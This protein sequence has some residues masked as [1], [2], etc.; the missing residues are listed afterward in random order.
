MPRAF[1][2]KKQQNKSVEKTN[3]VV[4]AA[5]NDEDED[6]NVEDDEEVATMPAHEAEPRRDVN[7]STGEM[8]Y[9]MHLVQLLR[10]IYDQPA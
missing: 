3:V 7:E 6:V 9:D 4:Y 8:I 10:I 5:A 1:L 2:I